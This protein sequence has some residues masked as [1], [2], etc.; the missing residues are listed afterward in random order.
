MNLDPFKQYTDEEIW[1]SLTNAH[2]KQY[3]KALPHG[4][5]HMVAEGGENL[6]Y[7]LRIIHSGAVLFC[8]SSEF[9]TLHY[10][11]VTVNF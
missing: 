3:V 9:H 4:L 7:A 8:V 6:R 11:F 10:R 2:L 1:L 5:S